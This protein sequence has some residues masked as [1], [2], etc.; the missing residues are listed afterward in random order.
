MRPEAD[1]GELTC[2]DHSD[3]RLKHERTQEVLEALSARGCRV[4]VDGTKLSL[5]TQIQ[6]NDCSTRRSWAL[7]SKDEDEGTEQSSV[8]LL[9]PKSTT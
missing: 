6:C 3:G 2:A 5:V 7:C 1:I 8:L 4:V 9:N